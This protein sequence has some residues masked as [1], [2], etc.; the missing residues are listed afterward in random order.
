[1]SRYDDRYDDE[2]QDADDRDY[3]EHDY[4]VHHVAVE[5][6]SSIAARRRR[7]KS[8]ITLAVLL[9]G[10]FFA[11]WWAYSYYKAS[12][13]T[14]GASKPT[15]SAAATCQPVDPN[16]VTPDKVTVNVYNATKRAGLAGSVSKEIAAQG[17]VLGKVAND[18]AKRAITAP[19]EVRFGPTGK[20]GAELVMKSI[21]T[22]VVPVEDTRTDATVDVALGD[23]YAALQPLPSPT[24]SLPTCP[25]SPSPSPSAS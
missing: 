13:E 15:S 11:F 7:R 24:S 25:A 10:L 3:E 22:G 21:G 8:L 16:A 17:Y 4:D 18:P 14:P 5:S 23:A 2:G 1:M 12:N 19:A 20:Q 9:L 6:D